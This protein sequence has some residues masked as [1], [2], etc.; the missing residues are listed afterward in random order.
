[1]GS[2]TGS[3]AGSEAIDVRA[4]DGR[5]QVYGLLVGSGSAMDV[6]ASDSRKGAPHIASVVDCPAE[7]IA[8]M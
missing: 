2:R 6:R 3:E 1:M 8:Q 7:N 4:S 5:A